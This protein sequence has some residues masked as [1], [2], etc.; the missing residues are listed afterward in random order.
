MAKRSKFKRIT[1]LRAF[2]LLCNMPSDQTRCKVW[3]YDEVRRA[4]IEHVEAT[5]VRGRR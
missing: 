4:L 3:A 5:I 2:R 1:G